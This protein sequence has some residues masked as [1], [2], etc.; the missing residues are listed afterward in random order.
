CT[1]DPK[2]KGTPSPNPASAARSAGGASLPPP[3]VSPR[4]SAER[5]SLSRAGSPRD[6][7]AEGDAKRPLLSHVKMPGKGE[8]LPHVIVPAT[9]AG[10]G[11]GWDDL[12]RR[13]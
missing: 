13:T 1:C 10:R 7:V 2:P 4:H 12:S 11:P 3:A 6:P 9:G 5:G 8:S